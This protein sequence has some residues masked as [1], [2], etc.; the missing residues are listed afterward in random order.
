VDVGSSEGAWDAFP[1][2]PWKVRACTVLGSSGFDRRTGYGCDFKIYG[3]HNTAACGVYRMVACACPNLLASLNKRF[4]AACAVM[5]KAGL[6]YRSVRYYTPF[7]SAG[8]SLQ[9]HDHQVA[10]DSAYPERFLFVLVT[11]LR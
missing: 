4:R 11:N 10:G 5:R 3:H 8:H 2:V 6:V 1:S 9:R 7:S